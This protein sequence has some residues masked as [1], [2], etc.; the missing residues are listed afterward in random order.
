MNS[1]QSIVIENSV[2]EGLIYRPKDS[3]KKVYINKLLSRHKKQKIKEKI[4][5]LIF[6][7]LTCVLVV[8][9]GIVVSL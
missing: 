8:I 2:D 5:T 1:E 4:E 6:V 7:C 3:S 9:L